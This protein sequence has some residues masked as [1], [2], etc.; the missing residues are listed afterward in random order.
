LSADGR[1]MAILY[2]DRAHDDDV[3]EQWDFRD[4]MHP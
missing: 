1:R 2:R 4:S 3:V